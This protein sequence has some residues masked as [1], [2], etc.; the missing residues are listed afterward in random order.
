MFPTTDL[1]TL[2]KIELPL[3][4]APMAGAATP[5]LI[6]A[7]CDAGAMGSLPAAYLAPA[8]LR[9]QASEVRARTNRPFNINLFV[10]PTAQRDDA[11]IARALERLQPMRNALGLPPAPAP[12]KFCEDFAEQFE[13]LLDI[14]PAVAS[15]T[16]GLLDAERMHALKQRGIVV[17]GTATTVAE[18]RAWANAGADAIAAQGS[19]AGAH[20]GTFIGSFEAGMVGTMA[21]VPQIVDA[22]NVPVIAAGGIMDGRGVAAALALG[23]SGVQ[24]GTAFLTCPESGISAAWK[25]ALRD[26]RD[27][28]TLVTRVYSGRHARGLVNEFMQRLLPVQADIPPF[29]IQ[30]ALTSGI[31]Q[32]ASKANRP[33]YQSLFAGQAAGMSR[34]LPAAEL[35]KAL[36]QETKAALLKAGNF[37]G[38]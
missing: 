34:G 21:L 15:L 27:D 24:L 36:M 18:A 26:A 32:A 28:Q 9:E 14:R 20:R 16:F 10:A 25:Q 3:I 23:A 2:L 11:Q 17:I 5:T 4:Q 37:A 13:T 12:E 38:G 35:V 8:S 29:P 33:E 7:V 22:V 31:R 30:N 1:S 6:A 19:E